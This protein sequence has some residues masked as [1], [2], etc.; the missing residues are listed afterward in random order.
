M[1]RF[2]FLD[3]TITNEARI[4]SA[5]NGSNSDFW[6]TSLFVHGL[7]RVQFEVQSRGLG[8]GLC[9]NNPA[10]LPTDRLVDRRSGVYRRAFYGDPTASGGKDNFALIVEFAV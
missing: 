4:S 9:R 1:R 7:E 2:I 8:T 3:R 10:E 6:E 5:G